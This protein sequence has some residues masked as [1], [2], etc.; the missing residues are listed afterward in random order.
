[1]EKDFSSWR[2]PKKRS[3]ESQGYWNI[4]HV[5]TT[6]QFFVHC[7]NY[8][9]QRKTFFWKISNIKHFL[10]NQ[11]N[12]YIVETLLF[13]WNG[14]IDEEN[15]SV[16]KS[17]IKYIVTTERF[18]PPML[19]IHLSKWPLPLKSLIDLGSPYVLHLIH[20][21]YVICFS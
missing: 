1:M 6:I 11:N 20:T 19:W 9:N 21:L 8:S 12:S 3:Y 17:T 5:E 16:V 14:L 15:E 18:I 13:G 4:L 10:L 2:R 7:S